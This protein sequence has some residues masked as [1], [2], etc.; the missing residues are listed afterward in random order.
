MKR[1][2]LILSG[3]LL[4]GLLAGC[5]TTPPPAESEAPPPPPPMEKP[6]RPPE[7]LRVFASTLNVR[8]GPGTD[9]DK[10]ATLERWDRLVLLEASG[11]WFWVRLENGTK[12]WVHGDYVVRDRPCPPDREK[13]ILLEEPP[14]S[15]IEGAAGG[16]IL[17]EV[18]VN[19]EGEVTSARVTENTTGDEALAEI[20]LQ[21]ARQL[22]FDPPVRD[23][24][25]Q[26]F[27]TTYQRPF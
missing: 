23:C 16:R 7:H 10:V 17:V 19:A 4:L 22:R 5:T 18:K 27:T 21:E 26:P 8:S 13:P 1:I 9:Y 15:F 12:G 24:E 20:A 6:K 3:I 14:I 2:F 25:P 11:E